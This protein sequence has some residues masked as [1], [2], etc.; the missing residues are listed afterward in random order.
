MHSCNIHTHTESCHKGRAGET[1][2]RFGYPKPLWNRATELLML[3]HDEKANKTYALV[4]IDVRS[5]IDARI[6]AL[7]PLLEARDTRV[8]IL[9]RRS[10]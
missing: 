2:C 4:D 8:V 3:V 1:K 5:D 10:T 6:A 9:E 7:D